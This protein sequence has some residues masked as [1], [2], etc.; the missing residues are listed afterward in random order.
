MVLGP[1]ATWEYLK[2]ISPAIPTLRKIKDHFE[3]S[4]NHFR[5]GKSHTDPGKD[6]DV[7]KLREYY[8]KSKAHV[9]VPGRKLANTDQADDYIALGSDPTKLKATITRWNKNRLKRRSTLEDHA[10]EPPVAQ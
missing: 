8:C 1:F 5:R 3:E 10:P 7:A 2:K 9:Y 6:A 4:F